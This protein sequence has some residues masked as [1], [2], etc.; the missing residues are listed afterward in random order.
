[1]VTPQCISNIKCRLQ[2][3]CAMLRLQQFQSQAKGT[4]FEGKSLQ[5]RIVSGRHGKGHLSLLLIYHSTPW[6]ISII[7]ESFQLEGTFKGHLVQLPCTEQGH[8]QLDQVA[9]SPVY[10]DLECLQGQSSHHLSRQPVPV[11][12][13]ISLI[14]LALCFSPH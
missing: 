11:L 7:T 14:Y 6:S 10:A 5:I 9:Q 2:R 13:N 4:G 12:H 3:A 1:M 8:L